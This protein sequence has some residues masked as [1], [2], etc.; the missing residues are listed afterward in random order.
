MREKLSTWVTVVSCVVLLSACAN[1]P[2]SALDQTKPAIELSVLM[3]KAATAEKE[4]HFD[5]ALRQYEEAAK[6][7]PSS[8]LPWVRIAQIRYEAGNY[9]EAISAAQQAVAREE[10]NNV[11][12]SILAVSG[13][14]VSSIALDELRR[15]NDLSGSVQ[16]EAQELARVLRESLGEQVLVPSGGTASPATAASAAAVRRKPAVVK[17]A[18]K[19]AAETQGG[20][21]SPFGAL[22]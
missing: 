16:K 11:A 18:A 15:H 3:D 17:P 1:K 8:S 9:G 7:Y 13:L 20:S 19:P 2:T 12:H 4:K 6:L 14:R 10:R 21:G 5:V 22:Q